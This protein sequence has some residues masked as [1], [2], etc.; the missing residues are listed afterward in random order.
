MALV[1]CHECGKELSTKADKCPHCGAKPKKKTSIIVW[2]FALLFGFVIFKAMSPPDVNPDSTSPPAAAAVP[3]VNAWEYTTNTDKVSGK[4]IS[5]AIILSNNKFNLDFPYQGG[6]FGKLNI[7]KHPRAGRDVIFTI[8]KGQ[9]ICG[10]SGCQIS[11]KFDDKPAY[12][13][14]GTEAADHSSDILFLG[15]YDKLVRDLKA[16]KKMV[17]EVTFYQQGGKVFEFNT[18]NLKWD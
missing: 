17:I 6:T 2:V 7:R 8:N 4:P 15:S 9:L 3:K 10:V 18:A 14:G 12:K 11:V 16:S 1:K 5:H 13:V